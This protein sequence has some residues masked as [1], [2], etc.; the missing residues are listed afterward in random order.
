LS[1]SIYRRLLKL[2]SAY[3]LHLLISIVAALIFVV[4]NSASIWLT[5]SLINNILADFNDIVQQ[6]AAWA[7]DASLTLNEKLKFWTNHFILRD[8]ARES[9]EVLC[10]AILV[11]FFAKN[12]FLY[13]K[14]ILLQYVQLKLVTELRAQLYEHIH[15]LS[16][17]FFHERPSGA[18]SSIVINDV[19]QMRAALSTSFQKLLVEPINILAFVFLLF[20]IS[21]KLA[22]VV[23]IIL[24]LAGVIIVT[25]GRSI[26]RKSRRTQ[27]KIAHIMDILTE[28]LSSIRIVKAFVMERAEVRK[29]TEEMRKYFYLLFRRARLDLLAGPFTE[30]IGVVIGVILLYYGG[31]EVLAN[32]GISPEDFIRFIFVLFSVLGPIKQLSNVNVKLQMG[33]ASA[34]RVF[35]LLDTPPEITDSPGAIEKHDFNDAIVFQDV[36]FEYRSSDE[37]VLRGVSFEIKKGE[38]VALVGPSGAGKSTIADLI[39]R[40]YD[41]TSGAVLID[42]VDVRNITLDSLR[43]LMGIVTQEVILFNDTIRNNISYGMESVG[44]E[45][46]RAAAK[47]ANALEFIEQMPGGFDCYIGEH[48]V[49]LS[50]GQRQRLAI[51][52][53]LLKNPPILILDEATSSLDA[54]SEKLVQQAIEQLMVDRTVLVIAHRLSTIV[55]AKKIIVLKA[56]QIVEMGTHEELLKQVSMYRK[57]YEIQFNNRDFK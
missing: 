38:V 50:G 16:L 20:V 28:T 19:Q 30:S 21:W 41:V 37:R 44:D 48:G 39:P 46:I 43:A 23:L 36:Y 25:I 54:E 26:R 8:T 12:L 55:N 32:K 49:K 2:V 57:L 10:I 7:A 45:E 4:L 18:I 27:Q 15:S 34:E 40:F 35:Q 5:A 11:I 42:G 51:A 31:I 6:Q 3:W 52:R 56:G 14:N 53:A 1:N 47:A 29:F 33:I 13:L 24:P 17:A 22:L 9:L